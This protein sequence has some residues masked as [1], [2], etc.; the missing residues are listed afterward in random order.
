[1]VWI[2]PAGLS[3][4]G[5]QLGAL[6]E[7]MIPGLSMVALG[8]DVFGDAG[9]AA[10]TQMYARVAEQVQLDGAQEVDTLSSDAAWAANS[11]Q[12]LDDMSASKLRA[13]GWTPR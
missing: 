10:A 1:M 9:L 8:S 6:R 12:Q 13:T 11:W 2:D 4:V 7:A 3:A 5:Q